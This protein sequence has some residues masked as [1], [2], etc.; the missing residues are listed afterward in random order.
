M[1]RRNLPY[2]KLIISPNG[3]RPTPRD[4]P[5]EFLEAETFGEEGESILQTARLWRQNVSAFIGPQETCVHEARLAAS[6]NLPMISH[7][8][9]HHDTSNKDFSSPLVDCD[10]DNVKFLEAETFGEEGESILQTAR[11]WRQNVSAFIGPQETCV[12]EARLAASFNLPM[13]SHFCSHHDT[14]NKLDWGNAG[15]IS[16]KTFLTMPGSNGLMR[17]AGQPSNPQD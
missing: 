8:C 17:G 15:Y 12:H 13:I 1:E 2:Q 10:G 5:C 14:S 6:F 11:L 16:T 3:L 7:F 9:S 4:S